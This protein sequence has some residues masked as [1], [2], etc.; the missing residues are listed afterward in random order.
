MNT[1]KFNWGLPALLL[2]VILA[3]GAAVRFHFADVNSYWLDELY[4]VLVYGTAHDSVVGVLR[5][6]SRSIQLP[7]NPLIIY[8]GMSLLGDS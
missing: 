8:S 3:A 2:V 5:R 7:L 6:V 4:S 1:L